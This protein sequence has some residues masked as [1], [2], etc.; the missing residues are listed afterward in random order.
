[1]AKYNFLQQINIELFAN[2]NGSLMVCQD[3]FLS[4]F[5]FSRLYSISDVPSGENR[6]LHAHKTLDQIFFALS[7]NFVLTATDGVLSDQIKLTKGSHGVYM[8]HGL[9]RELSDFSEDAIC[10]VLAS[11][12]YNESDYIRSFEEFLNWRKGQ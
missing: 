2:N 11:D 8:R 12:V 1:M 10:L 5:K 4:E 6:G 7:G 9:W 3:K